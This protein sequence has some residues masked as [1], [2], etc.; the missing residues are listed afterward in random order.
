[1]GN[2]RS[3]LALRFII[4]LALLAPMPVVGQAQGTSQYD[5]L[6]LIDCSGSMIGLPKGSGATVITHILGAA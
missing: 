5:Y 6:F 4:I 3:D 2:N 1:M